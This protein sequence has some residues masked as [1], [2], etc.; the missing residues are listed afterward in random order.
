LAA[1]A[2]ELARSVHHVNDDYVMPPNAVDREGFHA[3]V[4]C[5]TMQIHSAAVLRCSA[6]A[7]AVF[8][9]RCYEWPYCAA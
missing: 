3:D 2:K 4:V 1:A 7:F 6:F 8:D 5:I 9:L